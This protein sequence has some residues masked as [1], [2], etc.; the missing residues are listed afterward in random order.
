MRD[1]KRLLLYSLFSLFLLSSGAMLR[2]QGSA[3]RSGVCDKLKPCQIL[4]QSDAERILGMPARQI[5]DTSEHK[6]DVRQCMCAYLGASKDKASG[7]DV[8]LFFALEQDETKPSAEQARQVLETTKQDNAH[9]LDIQ[10]LKGI[11][12]E[13]IMFS[14]DDYSHFIMARRGAI[15][16]RFQVKKSAN[17]N[18][19]DELKTFAEKVFKQL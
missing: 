19:L 4:A 13:A 8:Y 9:D 12:D 6:G 1:T 2:A 18:S 16:A 10:E 17:K 3:S 11:G 15:I 14:N 7:Q 5:Q